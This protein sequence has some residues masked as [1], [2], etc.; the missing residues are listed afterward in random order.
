MPLMFLFKRTVNVS[1]PSAVTAILPLA[2]SNAAS[3]S[4]ETPSPL[5]FTRDPSFC[6]FSTSLLPVKRKPSSNV[7]TSCLL[8]FLSS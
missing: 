7:A 1:V 8:L 2:D 6:L 5:I 4:L 3:S